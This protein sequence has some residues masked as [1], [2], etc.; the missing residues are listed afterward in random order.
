MIENLMIIAATIFALGLLGLSF[1]AVFYLVGC[2]RGDYPE[3]T[4]SIFWGSVGFVAFSIGVS[5]TLWFGYYKPNFFSVSYFGVA[6]DKFDEAL[7]TPSVDGGRQLERRRGADGRCIIEFIPKKSSELFNHYEAHCFPHGLRPFQIAA[8]KDFD[9]ECEAKS[10]FENV[11]E[12]L[13]HKY[14]KPTSQAETDIRYDFKGMSI[15]LVFEEVLVK[16]EPVVVDGL[17]IRNG[18]FER[19][20]RVRYSVFSDEL[21][22]RLPENVKEN[23]LWNNERMGRNL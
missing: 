9:S 21:I 20:Q 19:M 6:L 13:K 12:V 17:I 5:L 7:V 22:K 16:L 4:K 1:P 15:E 8:Y 18:S 14:G 11:S 10:H 3:S 23:I 2:L